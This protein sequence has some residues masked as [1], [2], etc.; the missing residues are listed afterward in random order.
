[1]TVGHNGDGARLV[2]GVTWDG[3][4]LNSHHVATVNGRNHNSM[5]ELKSPAVTTGN[6]VVTYSGNVRSCV[7]V[8]VFD[9]VDQTT[10][11]DTAV[12]TATV[13]AAGSISRSVTSESGD[14]VV[15][16]LCVTDALGTLTSGATEGAGQTERYDLFIDATQDAIAA[17][18]T[19]AGGASVTMSWTFTDTENASI[20]ATNINGTSVVVPSMDSWNREAELPSLFAPA[21]IVS[22]SSVGTSVL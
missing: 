7:G 5:W 21:M 18:S 16:S 4:S 11:V 20:I 10:P 19:E 1:M 12:E 2:T 13:D 3:T 17:G 22:G 8:M 9:N 14:L 6:I 15:D